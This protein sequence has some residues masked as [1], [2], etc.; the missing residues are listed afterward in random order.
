MVGRLSSE[1][2]LILSICLR[3]FFIIQGEN[4]IIT[5]LLGGG[6]WGHSDVALL[7]FLCFLAFFLFPLRKCFQET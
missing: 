2:P 6:G 5:V 1:K 4:K 7:F 3:C